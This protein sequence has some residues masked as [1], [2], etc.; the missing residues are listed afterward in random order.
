MQTLTTIPLSGCHWTHDRVVVDKTWKDVIALLYDENRYA[1]WI[2]DSS[3][4]V[5]RMR[6]HQH[7][8]ILNEINTI[9]FLLAFPPGVIPI[10]ISYIGNDGY[11]DLVFNLPTT[12][13]CMAVHQSTGNLYFTSSSE[14]LTKYDTTH[15]SISKVIP[16]GERLYDR[17]SPIDVDGYF[18]LWSEKSNVYSFWG[19]D[20]THCYQSASVYSGTICWISSDSIRGRYLAIDRHFRVINIDSCVRSNPSQSW[21]T[22]SPALLSN[23]QSW[24]NCTPS[25]DNTYMITVDEIALITPTLEVGKSY[26]YTSMLNLARSPLIANGIC[27]GMNTLFHAKDP[28]WKL[29]GDEWWNP[30]YHCGILTTILP[31]ET[32]KR[33][34]IIRT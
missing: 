9:P 4:R 27:N 23:F 1:L 3:T 33:R 29:G 22:Q 17:I 21:I 10:C 18:L 24:T 25:S 30:Y 34:K 15:R 20:Q 31:N 11:I 7:Q 8:E 2:A 6:M 14:Y 12:P 16:V 26:R 19:P 28:E 13:N 32:N 5:S